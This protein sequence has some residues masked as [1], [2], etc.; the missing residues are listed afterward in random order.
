M[1]EFKDRLRELMN[2]KRIKTAEKLSTELPIFIHPN[3]IRNY[4]KG[5]SPK[6][7][8]KYE[9]LANYFGVTTDYLQGYSNAKTID[10]DIKNI[11][12]KYGLTEKSLLALERA[13]SRSQD[14]DLTTEINAI[15]FLLEDLE[16]NPSNSIITCIARYFYLITDFRIVER[17]KMLGSD[18]PVNI[19]LSGD[20]LASSFLKNIEEHL[21]N[22]RK[23]I[24]KEGEK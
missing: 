11:C 21:I 23:Y 5:K 14:L 1:V 8:E 9:I 17:T 10:I 22:A 20:I 7:F 4:L 19:N 18:V 15:N 6:D 2:E 3:T 16:K 12:N 24:N 13:N